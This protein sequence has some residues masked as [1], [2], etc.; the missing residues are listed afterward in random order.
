MVE[1]VTAAVLQMSSGDNVG[2]NLRLAD[3]LLSDAARQRCSIAFLPENFALMGRQEEDKVA[4][5]E[6]RGSGLIQEFLADAARRHK[7]WVVAGSLPLR[8][9]DPARCYGACV[10]FDAGGDLRACYRKVH[11][12]DVDVP[13]AQEQYRESATLSAGSDLAVVDTPLGRLG[14]SICYDLRFPEMF[15]ALVD[16]GATAFSIPAAF[17]E[18]T[19][20]AHWHI[21]LRARAIENLAYVIAAAQFGTHANGRNTFGHSMI[22]DPWGKVLAEQASGNIALVA[23]IDTQLPERIRQQFPA[24]DHRRLDRS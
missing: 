15:R 22:I 14:L 24:L 8:A 7:L 5:A 10:V 20:S 23:E 4:I 11:L 2:D 21:L 17:T 3:S 9:E 12:F 18:V 13:H 1:T 16:E 19:G 6:D